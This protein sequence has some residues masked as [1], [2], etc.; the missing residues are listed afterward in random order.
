MKSD[1]HKVQAI[2]GD[3]FN[4]SELA[5]LKIR[6]YSKRGSIASFIAKGTTDEINA[7][8]SEKAPVFF[9]TIPLTLE[10]I[11]ISEMEE[12]GY[13]FSKLDY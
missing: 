13:D 11:F 2:F 8:L 5:P 10:E 7:L 4:L 3:D 1:I 9:E 12:K 6:G